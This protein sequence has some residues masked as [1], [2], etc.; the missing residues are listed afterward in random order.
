MPEVGGDR[1]TIAL[2]GG[3]ALLALGALG[4]NGLQ[5]YLAGQQLRA[6][7]DGARQQLRAYIGSESVEVAGLAAPGGIAVTHL[8]RN[9]GATPAHRVNY[10]WASKLEEPNAAGSYPVDITSL[11]T[12]SGA[13]LLP[14]ATASYADRLALP[15]GLDFAKANRVLIYYG[16]IHYADVY[17]RA[18]ISRFCYVVTP[19][20]AAALHK[21]T[22]AFA[23]KCANGNDGT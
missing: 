1:T 9:F 14:Q 16:V 7:E 12:A 17:G 10:G 23:G 11:D 6:S 2:A 22:P 21:G 5:A 18:Q 4:L 13:W 20:M 19:E 8:I 15:P 3:A